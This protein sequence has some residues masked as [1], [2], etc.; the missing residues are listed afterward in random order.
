MPSCPCCPARA[1]SGVGE[2]LLLPGLGRVA[3]QLVLHACHVCYIVNPRHCNRNTANISQ[4]P[5]MQTPLQLRSPPP[6]G[7]VYVT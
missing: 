1:P 2:G 6:K 5:H 7:D 4:C 3:G